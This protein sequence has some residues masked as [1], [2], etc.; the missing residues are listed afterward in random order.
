[1]Q[2]DAANS[3]P[4]FTVA[5]TNQL[6]ER[7]RVCVRACCFFFFFFCWLHVESGIKIKQ[8]DQ[9]TLRDVNSA[10]SLRPLLLLLLPL[11]LSLLA[12]TATAETQD[13]HRSHILCHMKNR[14]NI[15]VWRDSW[16]TH[17]HT[18]TQI[19]TQT[20][21]LDDRRL[22]LNVC[23]FKLQGKNKS[24]YSCMCVHVCMC[25]RR[26]RKQQNENTMSKNKQRF[27]L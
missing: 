25:V 18:L 4:R 23:A 12:A 16:V 19:E 13:L 6:K 9:Q 5:A 26:K 14:N 10:L 1:M 11:P 24:T 7:A 3:S 15:A 17:T 2:G 20:R 27:L 21:P 22:N 8:N